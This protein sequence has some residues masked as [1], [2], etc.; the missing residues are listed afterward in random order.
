MFDR[1]RVWHTQS[2]E[3]WLIV[4][5][6]TGIDCGIPQSVLRDLADC[7][8]FDRYRLRHTQSF[9]TWLIVVCLTG[10]D[11]SIPQSVLRDLA[12]CGVFDRYRLRHT[13]PPARQSSLLA[14]INS[15]QCSV[16]LQLSHTSL[17]TCGE[18]C[19]HQQ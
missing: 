2:F 9:E 11:C 6:L 13:H 16:Y 12:D 3:T 19:H 8:V 10:I 18:K 15:L 1:Y 14:D 7:G 4:V 5:C 17:H